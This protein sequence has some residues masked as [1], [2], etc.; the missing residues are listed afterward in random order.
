MVYLWPYPGRESGQ[1]Y[2]PIMEHS[3]QPYPVIE[4][5]L[6]SHPTVGY[7]CRPLPARKLASNLAQQW[8][9]LWPTWLW[10]PDRKWRGTRE[11]LDEGERG[12]WKSWLKTQHSKNKDRGIRS[13]HFMANWWGESGSSD[14]FYFLGLQNHCRQW[15]Q[16]CKLI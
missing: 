14:R 13:Y 10:S 5:C 11:P 1:W 16:S 12:E 9:Q 7:I 2:H 15:L 6:Q 4:H 3:L 8:P